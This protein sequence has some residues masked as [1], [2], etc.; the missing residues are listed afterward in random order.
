MRTV[1]F[2][3][4]QHPSCH[5]LHLCAELWPNHSQRAGLPLHTSEGYNFAAVGHFANS[6][7]MVIEWAMHVQIGEPRYAGV[8]PRQKNKEEEDKVNRRSEWRCLNRK[9][10]RK[11]YLCSFPPVFLLETNLTWNLLH[12]GSES[13]NVQLFVFFF[14]L[15]IFFGQPFSQITKFSIL[16]EVFCSSGLKKNWTQATYFF[17]FFFVVFFFVYY[18]LDVWFFWGSMLCLSSPWRRGKR[19]KIRW[20][21]WDRK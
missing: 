18:L 21:R 8:T 1:F 14:I 20:K 2:S 10:G 3:T 15:L 19:R 7:L 11:K 6:P 5:F 17:L 16:G 12:F 9:W 4:C 13:P